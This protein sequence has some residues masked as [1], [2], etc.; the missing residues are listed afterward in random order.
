M[1]SST[2]GV[3]RLTKNYFPKKIISLNFGL[4]LIKNHLIHD[5]KL[6]IV[7]TSRF[8]AISAALF[9]VIV[10][11]IFSSC[12]DEDEPQKLTPS[13][14]TLNATISTNG[15]G[16]VNF[17][18]TA[19]NT[20][21]FNFYFGEDPSQAP[22]ISTTGETQYT[23][24]NSGI[25]KATVVAY[26]KDNL[27]ISKELSVEIQVNEPEIPTTGY[28]TP[29]TYPNMSLVWQDEFDGSELNSAN[30]THETGN[31]IGGWGNNELQ[32]Y[33]SS[34]TFIQDGH[35][36]IKAKK[37]SEGGFNYTSSRIIT[38]G[39]REF[40][41]GRID[42]RALLPKGQGIWPA[43]WMLGANIS[44]PGVG[45]PKCGEIDI[46]ELIGGTGTGSGRNDKIYGTVHWDNNNS[47]AQYGG[48][49][50]LTGGK[51]F[52]DEFHVFSIV[53]D[54]TKIVWYLDDVQFHIIDTT[55][56]ELSEFQQKYF[57]IFNIA[58][59]GNWPGSPDGTTVFP[60][61]MYVDYVR[62][63]Q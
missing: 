53:W 14:L 38:K 52:A 54:E 47:Y 36:V 13:N 24:L 21:K 49:K 31:G 43:L 50:T 41:Y 32:F 37:E 27:F 25:Y 9:C 57:F 11:S 6:N 51:T 10:L 63:F 60:Q 39:K 3:A 18:A 44:E 30:W 33:K 28:T 40:K 29:L 59:G 35:L 42:I 45:W 34:N 4:Y 16:L 26:S 55:P 12:A 58:V 20:E 46:M 62:V 2:F 61:R 56:A 15:S 48:N 5:M 17:S 23:Y 22:V 1:R 19:E 7:F 8:L